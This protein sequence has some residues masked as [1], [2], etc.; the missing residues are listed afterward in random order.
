MISEREN[1][2]LNLSQV[3]SQDEIYNFFGRINLEK[4]FARKVYRVWAFTNEDVK[5]LGGLTNFRNKEIFSVL[6]SADQVIHFLSQGAK[7]IIS[8]DNRDLACLFSEFKISALKNLSFK[9]FREIFLDK[10]KENSKIYFEK[11]RPDLSQVARKLFDYLFEGLPRNILLTL[12]KSQ[13]FYNESWYFLRKK[14]WLPYLDQPKDFSR[15]KK[16]INCILILNTDLIR[17]FRK[18]KRKFD[19][20]YT[21]NIFESKNYCPDFEK[22]FI[23]IDLHLKEKGEILVTVQGSPKKVI[24]ILKNLG[25]N[26]KIKEP[27]SKFFQVFLKTYAYYY[28][29]ARK[30]PE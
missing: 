13:F 29:L 20:I 17:A 23:Q 1:N 27:K 30:A 12:Q 11:I 15:V 2:L 25:Y 5:E 14:N 8:C 26:F 24:S 7:S 4:I 10:K 9:E 21:S 28:I 3:I 6:G 19:L 22:T 16:R 18:I